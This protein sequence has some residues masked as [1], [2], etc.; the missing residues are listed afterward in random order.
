[1]E[2]VS[3]LSSTVTLG[4]GGVHGGGPYPLKHC[5]IGYWWGYMEVVSNLS[6]TVSLGTGGAHGG[7]TSLLKHCVTG[8]WR[9]T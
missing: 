4:T 5:G 8:Y 7:G 6:S 9:C 3:N 1:M 2:V